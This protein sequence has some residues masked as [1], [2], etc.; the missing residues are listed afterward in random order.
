MIA[1]RFL[2]LLATLATIAYPPAHS[3]AAEEVNV[4]SHRHYETDKILFKKFTTQTGIKVNVV[5][6]K[7]AELIQRL[8]TEGKNS[9][10]DVL[11]TVDAGGL[12]QAKKARVLQPATSETLE[13]RVPAALRDRDGYWYGLTVRARVIAYAKDRVKPADLSTY[14]DLAKPV[15]KN[16]ILARSS[17]NI[18][19]QSLLASIIASGGEEEALAWAKDV[20]GNMA[21]PPRGNDRDQMRAVAGGLADI[22][23]VNTYYLGRLQS[24][25]DKKDRDVFEKIAAFFPN[26]D[27]AGRGTHINVS[28]AGVTAAAKNKA[29]AIKLIEFLASDEAQKDYAAANYEYPLDPS[30]NANELLKSWGAFKRD[31]L[32]LSVLGENNTEAVKIF[33]TAGWE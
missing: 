13:K 19:N 16:R 33:D 20:R 27:E 30:N 14:E 9:P 31:P 12:H 23:I 4:Y 10:A 1:S 29:N 32:P 5:K 24:S 17:G 21:R 15:W 25:S 28:G 3:G 11:I 8:I 18:Y 6:A 26:Q 22:A 2:I 7:A